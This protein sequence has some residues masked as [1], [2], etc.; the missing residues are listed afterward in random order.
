MK[1]I[2]MDQLAHTLRIIQPFLRTK[3]D[4][5]FGA[6]KYTIF[7]FVKRASIYNHISFELRYI[8]IYFFHKQE[9]TFFL[10]IY[11]V[12]ISAF[13]RKL[14][15]FEFVLTIIGWFGPSSHTRN[16]RPFVEE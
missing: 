3:T 5:R 13:L 14:H 10:N 4:L 11:Q 1:F 2:S 7:Q 16:K 8:L 6:D 9:R 15:F 12:L